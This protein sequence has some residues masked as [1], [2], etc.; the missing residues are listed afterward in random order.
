MIQRIQTVYIFVAAVLAATLLKLK[1]A[2]LVVKDEILT[3]SAKG[4]FSSKEMIFNGLPITGFIGLIVLLHVVVIFLY[5]NRIK[6]AT[7][8]NI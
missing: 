6:I 4:I 7:W 5:K 3:F 8:H 2:D 1:F